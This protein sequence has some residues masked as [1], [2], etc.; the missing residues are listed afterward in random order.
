MDGY[1]PEEGFGRRISQIG[2]AVADNS[3]RSSLPAPSST[4][5]I[6]RASRQSSSSVVLIFWCS[7]LGRQTTPGPRAIQLRLL[8]ALWHIAVDALHPLPGVDLTGC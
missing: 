8:A 4:A 3:K 5:K 2:S 1:S 6:I 7:G